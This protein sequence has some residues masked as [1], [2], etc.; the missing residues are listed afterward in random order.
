MSAR[1]AG[2]RRIR[3][4]RG[5][6]YRNAND[7]RI[8]ADEHLERIRHLAIAPAWRDVWICPRADGHL[9]ATGVDDAGRRQY[10]YHEQW[11]SRASARKFNRVL[12]FAR[13]LPAARSSVTRDLRK[14][15]GLARETVLAAAFRLLDA[16]L[17][18]VGSERYAHENGSVGL[19]TLTQRHVEIDGDHVKLRF[20]GKSGQPWESVIRDR[21]LARLLRQLIRGDPGEHLLSWHDG[22]DW[23]PL[24]ARDI[25]EDIRRR[26]KGDFSAKDFRTLRGTAVAARSLARAGPQPTATGRRNAVAHAFGEVARI[27]GNTPATA[28]SAYV[29]PR[30]VDL[31]E[32]G[33]VLCHRAGRAIESE[34]LELLD[35]AS[36]RG[37]DDTVP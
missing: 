37:N 31:Y 5:F 3:R 4:G 9:Q 29:D 26:T 33:E 34:L 7:A 21:D 18:R 11:T 12:P 36:R 16:G 17:L 1:A 14:K 19:T 35:P 24:A 32:H 27:L 6:E 23:R 13:A 28:R 25:N 15:P 22:A 2:W 8:S 10:L 20:P 30:V